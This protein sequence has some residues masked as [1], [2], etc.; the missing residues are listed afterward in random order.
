[1]LLEPLG[2]VYLVL[3]VGAMYVASC[4]SRDWLDRLVPG[5]L[6]LMPVTVTA[7]GGAPEPVAWIGTV[8]YV[9]SPLATAVWLARLSLQLLTMRKILTEAQAR[10]LDVARMQRAMNKRSPS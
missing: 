3:G 10:G 4:L 2:L 1:M 5:P 6:M 7:T 9:L 8:L